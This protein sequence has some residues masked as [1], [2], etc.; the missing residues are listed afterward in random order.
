[1]GE[2]PEVGGWGGGVVGRW[3]KAQS[4]AEKRRQLGTKEAS[5]VRPTKNGNL[6]F[7]LRPER[8]GCDSFFFFS[9][10]QLNCRNFRPCWSQT[11]VLSLSF[12]VLNQFHTLAFI[13]LGK[14]NDN[15]NNNKKTQD[16]SLRRSDIGILILFPSNLR[17]ASLVFMC[18]GI[19]LHYKQLIMN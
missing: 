15:N 19:E 12:A 13:N 11:A 5:D 8:H 17:S 2:G 7:R 3:R 18:S 9:S 4:R 14:N 16:R 10:F 1:M 6:F